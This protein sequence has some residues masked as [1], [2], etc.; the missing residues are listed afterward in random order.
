VGPDLTGVGRRLSA[1]DLLESVLLPSKTITDGYATTEIETL[2]GDVVVGRIEREDDHVVVLRPPLA[3]EAPVPIPKA[4]IRSRALSKSSNMPSGIL[5]V[6]RDLQILDLLAYLI[7][8]G[9][10]SH[11][12]FRSSEGSAQITR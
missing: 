7:S 1:R 2:A 4:D 6:L 10:A 9:D 8:D 5:N 3:S 12:A 11:A